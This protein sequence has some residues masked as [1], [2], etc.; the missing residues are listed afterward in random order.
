M[1]AVAHPEEATKGFLFPVPT[2]D[3]KKLHLDL[4]EPGLLTYFDPDQVGLAVID[5]SG[6]T[7]QVWGL[8][9]KV[10]HLQNVESIL[11]TPLAN[12]V[13]LALAGEA[14]T[15]HLD[16][17]RF[18]AAP[19]PAFSPPGALMLVT[20]AKDEGIARQVASTNERRA[21]ALKR[22]GKAL[23]MN[24]TLQPLAVAAVHAINSAGEM[25]AVLLWVRSNENGP[26]EL[27]ASVGANRAGTSALHNLN[28]ESG[29]SCAAELAA[30]RQEPLIIRRVQDNPIT[31]ELEGKFCYLK[32]GG[33]MVYPLVINNR[34]LGLLELISREHDYEFLE[35]AEHFFSISEHLALA[36]N[37][38]IMFENVE[39]LAAYDPLTG[40]AN[41]RTLQDF[42]HRRITE[43]QRSNTKIGLIMLDVD[44]FR[45]FNEEEGHDAGDMVLKMVTDVLKGAVRPYDLA[46]R[47]GGEE[48]TIVM[49]GASQE[50]TLAIAERIRKN[51]E[52]LEYV[53]ASGRVRHVTA[54]MGCAVFPANA[55][56]SASILKAA[57]TALFEAKRSG[58]NK[59]VLFQGL[60]TR[61]RAQGGNM[62]K[63]ARAAIPGDMYES[64]EALL[65]K[66]RPYL[67][68]IAPEMGLNDAQVEMLHAAILLVQ[69]YNRA[70]ERRDM[71]TIGQIESGSELRPIG[72]CLSELNERY[73]GQGPKGTSGPRIPLLSRILSVLLAIFLEHGRSLRTDPGRF[74]PE[75]VA[76]VGRVEAAA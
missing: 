46:A 66:A 72:P 48:F 57:D 76:I 19:Y 2:S 68:Q 23:T 56:D 64:C 28:T 10:R 16:S 1:K 8:A 24:Q 30:V 73:D 61:D 50:T 9:S 44:H 53:T 37:S 20:D 51:I 58:R 14:G 26:M 21:D 75:V 18:Y 6:Q 32:P 70:N 62:L 54:S 55:R 43:A 27:M 49:P 35:A 17:F 7:S 31:S 45:S 65:R 34:L 15:L 25:A 5:H 11:D 47:Y 74:D 63:A 33:V 69:V 41:H 36:L 59:S 38:A 3:G 13:S 12:L 40:I 67:S 71:D 52:A 60:Y 39:R 29:V 42:L 22:I 4:S